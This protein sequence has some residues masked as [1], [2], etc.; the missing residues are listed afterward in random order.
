MKKQKNAFRTSICC[1]GSMTQTLYPQSDEE[2]IFYRAST[3]APNPKT[4]S[5]TTTT[6]SS[7]AATA[8]TTAFT[9]MVGLAGGGAHLY[10]SP[11]MQPNLPNPNDRKFFFFLYLFFYSYTMGFCATFSV[12]SEGMCTS[13]VGICH[14]KLSW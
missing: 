6:T 1:T 10:P 5:G 13:R 7:V 3:L 9:D 4:F 2:T 11:P 14:I 12:P 8:S